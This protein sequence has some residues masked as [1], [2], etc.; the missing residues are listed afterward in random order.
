MD[1][2]LAQASEE[3]RG[4]DGLGAIGLGGGVAVVD[5][6]QIQIRTMPEF[7]ATDLAVTDDDERRIAERAIAALWLAMT[8]DGVAPGE[9]QHFLQDRLRQPS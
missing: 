4:I 1:D 3:L 9:G 5:E 6:H 7:D 2:A 8:R